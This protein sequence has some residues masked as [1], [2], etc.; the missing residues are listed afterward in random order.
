MSPINQNQIKK[1]FQGRHIFLAN[2]E[3][4][5]IYSILNAKL[6]LV[7]GFQYFSEKTHNIESWFF[8][9]HRILNITSRKVN[10]ILNFS[11]V[12]HKIM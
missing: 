4:L 8:T 6:H 3:K 10:L 2:C 1:T 12:T 7:E 11:K 5:W 9:Y